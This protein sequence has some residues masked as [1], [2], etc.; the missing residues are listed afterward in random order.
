MIYDTIAAIAT[1]AGKAALG[2]IRISGQK[3]F[4]IV[5]HLTGKDISI[6]QP[7]KMSRATIYCDDK[8]LDYGM[9]CLF[10]APHSYTGEDMAELYCHGN[11][12]IL[13]A[14]LQ[15]ILKTARLA[16]K[17]EFTLR[18]FLNKKIDLTQAEAIGQILSANTQK[19][20]ESA[21]SALQGNL[22]HHIKDILDRFTKLRVLFE[23]VIDFVED[24]VPDFD[25][26]SISL[27]IDEL[28]SSL[29]DL[30]ENAPNGIIIAGGLNVCLTGPPNVGKSSIFNALLQTERAIITEIPGTTR[31]FLVEQL[32]LDGY[33]IKIYDTAGLRDTTD[34]IEKIGIEKTQEL[35]NSADLNIY[36]VDCPTS[37]D[38]MLDGRTKWLKVFNKI[39][40][41]P[42]TAV[43]M[44]E[45]KGYIPCSTV[46]NEGLNPLKKAILSRLKTID[47]ENDSLITNARQLACVQNAHFSLCKAREAILSDAGYDFIAFDIISASA[48]LGEIIGKVS[49]DDVLDQIFADFCIG[50]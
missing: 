24:E 14:V 36:I 30:I 46:T 18:A 10:P 29:E 44:Y 35:V 40:L 12:F 45:K 27:E 49:N 31:D 50:K 6:Y 41:F 2:I 34:P 3:T 42:I 23:L 19:T 22:Y 11:D 37:F 9:L 5:Q 25:Q 33:L 17:G 43:A 8:V 20:H 39:D 26:Y 32:S 28:I 47:S 16:T 7:R 15:V 48:Y 1:P 21:V 13:S 38:D 4:E